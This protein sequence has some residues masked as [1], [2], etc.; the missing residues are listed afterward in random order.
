M[1]VELNT[2]EAIKLNTVRKVEDVPNA[3]PLTLG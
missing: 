3:L 1:P 2:L